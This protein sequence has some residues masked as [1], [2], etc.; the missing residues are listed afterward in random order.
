MFLHPSQLQPRLQLQGP[1]EAA[2]AQAAS[3][4]AAA[5]HV[6]AA[7]SAASAAARVF[8]HP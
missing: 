8:L 2:A 4:Q 6:A 7:A 5:A 1:F 3:A